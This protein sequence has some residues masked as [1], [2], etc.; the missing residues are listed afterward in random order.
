MIHQG[1][2]SLL[3]LRGR[4]IKYRPAWLGLGWAAF[5]VWSHMSGGQVTLRSSTM[6]FFEAIHTFY[7]PLPTLCFHLCLSVCRSRLL[8]KLNTYSRNFLEGWGVAWKT[9]TLILIPIRMIYIYVIWVTQTHPEIQSL[10]RGFRS[11]SACKL[12]HTSI[13]QLERANYSQSMNFGIDIQEQPS[14]RAQQLPQVLI[15]NTLS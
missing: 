12:H 8:K 11:P 3:S 9:S 5:T 1:Q 13:P 14:M 6:S 10:V 2:L 7:T 4:Q 15:T